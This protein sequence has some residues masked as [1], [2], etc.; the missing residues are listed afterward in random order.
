MQVQNVECRLAKVQIKRF[1]LGQ[2]LP[3]DVVRELE[4]HLRICNDC[5]E[6]L[7]KIRKELSSYAEVR[8]R[9]SEPEPQIDPE[10]ELD[11]R[12]KPKRR[13]VTQVLIDWMWPATDRPANEGGPFQRYGKTVLL[14]IVLVAVMVAMGTVLKDP[15]LLFGDRAATSLGAGAAVAETATEPPVAPP[16]DP[17][18]DA[19]P[20]EISGM[21]TMGMAADGD[22]EE[23]AEEPV[24]EPEP[25]PELD[26]KPE[27]QA[28]PKPQQGGNS[29][30][31]YL[32]GEDVTRR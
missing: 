13:T 20:G 26:P 28:D 10:P 14:T 31:V 12:P 23:E 21:G 3:P 9:G 22:G 6:E 2:E 30:R 5:S 1:L 32:N 24:E 25:E 27:P 18:E 15:T 11:S 16:V 8:M 19:E 17:A 4:G 29:V 7:E